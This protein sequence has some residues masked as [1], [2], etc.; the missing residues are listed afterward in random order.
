[1]GK[2]RQKPYYFV[3]EEEYRLLLEVCRHHLPNQDLSLA[4]LRSL[5]SGYAAA[6]TQSHTQ[7]L[8]T[9]HVTPEDLHLGDEDAS[10]QRANAGDV[11]L[12]ELTDLYKDLGC[13]LVDAKG[14]HRRFALHICSSSKTTGVVRLHRS[15]VGLYL[16]HGGTKFDCRC[17]RKTAGQGSHES[18]L[19][20]DL[21]CATTFHHEQ[22]RPESATSSKRDP[23][24]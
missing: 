3:S 9:S 1:M 4:A 7:T 11:T 14:Q 8:Q 16:Q 21:A 22:R 6:K 13:M 10:N 17:C 19:H 18:S 15:R 2:R 5:A 20:H 23:S 24:G 12:E